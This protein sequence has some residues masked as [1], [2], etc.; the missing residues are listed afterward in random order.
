MISVLAWIKF[1]ETILKMINVLITDDHPTLRQGV[2]QI[3]QSDKKR[4]IGLIDECGN[5]KELLK[6]LT[7]SKYDVI[8]LDISLPGRSGIDLIPDIKKLDPSAGILM[9][10]I[11]EDEQYAI[12]SFRLGAL[13][14]VIKT[15]S[16]DI[17]IEAVVKV[18]SG[19]RYV[20]PELAE[21]IAFSSP[22]N[23]RDNFLNLLSPREIQVASLLASGKGLSSIA[24][25]LSLSPKTVATYKNRILEK[26]EI[27]STI[28][29]IRFVI[30]EG[31]I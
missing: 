12:K 7:E 31:L 15:S 11:Y 18:A 5:G 1:N 14:Y 10:S 20:N 21:S 30:K 2:R 13:G 19:N 22:G 16:S 4:R 29:L 17:L 27:K 24:V 8:I 28:E 6:K 3:L 26:L 23:P 9:F 25:E